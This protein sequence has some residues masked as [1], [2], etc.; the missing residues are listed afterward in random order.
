MAKDETTNAEQ[1]STL[2]RIT[3]TVLYEGYS[4]FP[5]RRSSTKNVKPVPFGTIYPQ[6]YQKHHPEVHAA[7]QTECIIQGSAEE[8]IE[9]TVR[10]LHLQRKQLLKIDFEKF[11]QNQFQGSGVIEAGGETHTSGWRAIERKIKLGKH[12]IADIIGRPLEEKLLFE[13]EQ[14]SEMIYHEDG[15]VAGN[16][17]LKQSGINGNVKVSAKPVGIEEEGYKITVKITNTTRT[18]Q[19]E[20]CSRDEIYEQS[21]LSANTI[22]QTQEGAFI[23]QADPP[24]AWKE[25]SETLENINTW[26]VLVEKDD[27][28]MLSSPII[29]YDYPEIAPE[30]LGDLFDSTEIEELLLLQIAAL[31]DKEKQEIDQADGKMKAMLRRIENT[32]PEELMNLHG[33]L[34]EIKN[35]DKPNE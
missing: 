9:I 31:P 19:P 33:R 16:I 3:Q 27:R 22:L 10:F 8:T 4:V 29:L 35:E 30:S 21:L 14:S 20:S 5:Y 7:T 26:S 25:A 23:S 34:T 15:K 13:D 18:S 11:G 32:T 6:V 24:E 12:K 17:I 28:T 2:E 1:L